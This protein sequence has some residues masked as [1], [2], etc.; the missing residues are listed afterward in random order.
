[1]DC[2]ICRDENDKYDNANLPCFRLMFSFEASKFHRKPS[3]ELWIL[4]YLYSLVVSVFG[5][6]R[7]IIGPCRTT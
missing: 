3:C 1:M 6:T 5:I 4:T 2:H 7:P